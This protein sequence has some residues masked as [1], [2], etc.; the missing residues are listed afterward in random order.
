MSTES[1]LVSHWPLAGDT[2]DCV[3]DHHGQA[4]A[5]TFTDGPD[6]KA[7]GAAEFDGSRSH[8]RIED[9][10]ELRMGTGDFTITAWVR[11][12]APMTHVFGDILSKFD[13]VGRTG[14]NLHVAGSSPAYSAM[15][16]QRHVHFG[17]DDGYIGN[18]EDFG[19]PEPSSS[20]VTAIVTWQGELYAG[21]ADAETPEKACHV[22]RYGGD[23]SWHDCGRLCDDPD[24]LSVQSMLVHGGRLYAGSGNWDWARAQGA[25]PGFNPSKVHVYEYRGDAEWRDLGQ[26]GEG[27]RLMC[28]GSFAGDLFAGMDAGDG[29]GKVF[30]Y[31]GAEWHDC[32]A[33]DGLNIESFLPSGGALYVCT[34]GSIY[35]Y[36]GDTSW[37]CIGKDPHGINQI[38]SMAEVGG[39]LWIGTWPQGYVQRLDE[40]GEWTITGRLGIP[41]GLHECNEVMDLRVYNGKLY[42]ALIP[43]SQVWRYES[44][45]NWTLMTSLASRPDWQH[46]DV[47]TWCRVT[48]L[49]AYAGQL[50]AATGTC[51][52]RAEHQD[53][54]DTLGRVHGFT[55]GQVC[56]HEHDIGGSWTHVAAVREGKQTR[57]YI[58]GDLSAVSSA[59]ARTT[60]DLTNVSPLFIG[61][62]TQTYFKGAIS[63]VRICRGALKAVMA[64]VP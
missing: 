64:G 28:M 33:P 20:H 9:H 24:V 34:H 14:L 26:V 45:G 31:D 39:K 8:V 18:W 62:G 17:I 27:Y 42:A 5:L 13:P 10:P 2:K 25:I 35:R 57:L 15:S 58:N 19:K 30:R 3:G 44:D 47:N 23:Q 52:S 61:Y 50:C 60:F 1:Q 21:I 7:G 43:K 4:E 38:H 63:D 53:A 32:G 51:Y 49:N 36:E 12:Q 29:G 48:S 6:G 16:D 59:P 41:E 56:S 40:S 46:D 37:A 11:C 54:E 22:F 55:A